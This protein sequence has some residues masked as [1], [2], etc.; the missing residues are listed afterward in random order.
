MRLQVAE[1]RMKLGR[2]RI[3]HEEYERDL[4]KLEAHYGRKV[5]ELEPPTNTKENEQKTASEHEPTK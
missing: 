4:R 2:G 3:S 5:A 1:L